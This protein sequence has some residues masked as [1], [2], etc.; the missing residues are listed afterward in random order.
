MSLDINNLVR[1]IKKAAVEAVE[2]SSPFAMKIGEVAS[3]NPLKISI[4]QKIAISASQLLLTNAVRDYSIYM[5]KDNTEAAG[6]EEDDSTTPDVQGGT[7]KERYTVHLGL[8]TGEKVLLLRCDGGQRF[9][10]LDRL[11]VPE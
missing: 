5:T 8:K 3:V 6:G 7:A 4:N 9:I 10:V 11:E 2:A 1:L